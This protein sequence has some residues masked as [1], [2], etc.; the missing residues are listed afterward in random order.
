VA[1][2]AVLRDVQLAADEPLRVRRLPLEHLRER[3]PPE[4]GLRLLR[5]ET[6]EI[7]LRALVD[8]R[9]LHVRLRRERGRRREAAV[10]LGEGLERGAGL[11]CH[12]VPPA[13]YEAVEYVLQRALCASFERGEVGG[14]VVR[15]GQEPA[16]RVELTVVR[17]AGGAREIGLRREVGP[18]LRHRVGGLLR[19]TRDPVPRHGRSRR[20]GL[21]GR[22]GRL[23][24]RQSEDDA[25]DAS[26][27]EQEVDG[28]L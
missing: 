8:A 3:L 6:L 15:H 9:V 2:Q 11:G 16:E 19:P 28:Y 14:V 13:A 21:A 5:P 27:D 26:V 20:T 1:I 25:G 12:A 17:V 7:A 10:L 4:Q 22:S 23:A 24:F 18:E